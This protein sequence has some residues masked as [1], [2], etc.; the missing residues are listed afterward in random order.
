MNIINKIKSKLIVSCQP[1]IKG[2]L[3]DTKNIFALAKASID[4]GATGLRINDAKNIYNIK[5]FLNV[6]IIGIKNRKL[7]NSNIIITPFCKDVE[8]L[9][10]SGAEIIAFD[11]TLRKRPVTIEKIINTIH[12]NNCLAM[13]DCSNYNDAFNAVKLGADIIATTLSGYVGKT[14]T[15]TLPDFKLIKQFRKLNKPIIAEGRFNTPKLASE[16]IKRGAHSVVVGTAINRI[17]IITSWFVDK[18]NEL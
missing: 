11:A 7:K 9:A 14:K 8:N 12:K 10:T 13:A 5:K 16:A 15:P 18:I 2:P 1:V 4:G 6:P 3:D 17:E